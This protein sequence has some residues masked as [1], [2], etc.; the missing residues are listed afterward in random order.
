MPYRLLR[1][2]LAVG[3]KRGSLVCTLVI[4]TREI[5]I[6]CVA[7]RKLPKREGRFDRVIGNLIMNRVLIKISNRKRWVIEQR[8]G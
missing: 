4:L 8:N 5:Y 6:H 3:E 1:A 2:L 7:R